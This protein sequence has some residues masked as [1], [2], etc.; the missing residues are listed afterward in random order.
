[1]TAAELRLLLVDDHPVVRAGL[2]AMLED[3]DSLTVAA[4]AADGAAAVE[5][6]RK[7]E[8]LGTPLDL[9]LMDLQMSPGMDGVTAT[10]AIR[11]AGGP[12]VLILTTYDT[13]ADI[14]AAVE[15][16]AAGY[17]LKDAHPDELRAAVTA[18]V[19]GRTALSPQ[20]A[21]R[22]MGRLRSPVA[23]LSSRELELLEL[24]ATGLGNRAIAR[25]LFISEATVKTHLVHIYGKLGVDNRTAAIAE[26]QRL[27]IIRS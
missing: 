15:A 27:R 8:A 26:A 21:A 24:L 20:V 3:S 1:M 6:V 7:Q 17:M 19:E 2:R 23:A 9:V 18:A 14:L 13:D 12:P 16:G 11:A 5:E 22:L 25:Q 4:E 10:R